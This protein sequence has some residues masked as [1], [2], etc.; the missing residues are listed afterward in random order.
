MVSRAKNVLLTEQEVTALASASASTPKVIYIQAELERLEYPLIPFAVLQQDPLIAVR[1]YLERLHQSGDVR[2]INAV[3][4]L[5]AAWNS[6]FKDLKP[7]QKFSFYAWSSVPG[8]VSGSLRSVGLM[9]V[10][11]TPGP[12]HRRWLTTRPIL[13]RGEMVAWCVPIDMQRVETRQVE[14]V[15]LSEKNILRFSSSNTWLRTGE[16]GNWGSAGRR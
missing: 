4:Q 6:L 7:R 1:R 12:Q 8:V 15:L 9:F 11:A 3:Q 13:Y 10:I 2:G 5:Y 16:V 14:Q